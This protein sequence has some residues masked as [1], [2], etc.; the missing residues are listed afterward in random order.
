MSS[1][2]RMHR[3]ALHVLGEACGA[4]DFGLDHQTGHLVVLGQLA[5]LHQQLHR[6]EP[7][8]ARDDLVARAIGRRRHGQVLQQAE[9]RDRLGQ[10]TDGE[11]LASTHVMTRRNQQR[12][13]HRQQVASR[14]GALHSTHVELLLEGWKRSDASRIVSEPAAGLRPDRI[15]RF[16][17]PVWT[18]PFT[19]AARAGGARLEAAVFP[20]FIARD[21]SAGEGTAGSRE[22]A[23]GSVRPAALPSAR[24]RPAAP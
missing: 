17:S 10:F 15:P 13:R 19:S 11:V 4:T 12:Q 6:F 16:G 18:W 7:A 3:L 14:G 23:A 5:S 22:Q 9:A 2:E 20:E 21:A 24:T 8:P 1:I